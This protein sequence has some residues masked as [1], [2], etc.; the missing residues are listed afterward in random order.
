MYIDTARGAGWGGETTKA[1]IKAILSAGVAQMGGC[2]Y[3]ARATG[4]KNGDYLSPASLVALS[5]V[6]V[7]V[8]LCVCDGAVFV[9]SL[10]ECWSDLYITVRATDICVYTVYGYCGQCV[11]GKV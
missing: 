5:V 6:R 8:C 10:T 2:R 3:R 1:G 7:C 9:T 11:F 4:E